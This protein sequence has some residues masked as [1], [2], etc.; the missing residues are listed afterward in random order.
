MI[1]PARNE[2]CYHDLKENEAYF[3]NIWKLLVGIRLATVNLWSRWYPLV[4]AFFWGGVVWL[5]LVLLFGSWIV[6]WYFVWATM[7]WFQKAQTLTNTWVNVSWNFKEGL[8]CS[9]VLSKENI[10]TLINHTLPHVFLGSLNNW[11][12][13]RK[14]KQ[15][16]VESCHAN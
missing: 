5:L 6:H 7:I 15:N 9:W 16:G 13:S 11:I 3:K 8:G 2:L 1:S 10:W 4:S 12:C 14:L